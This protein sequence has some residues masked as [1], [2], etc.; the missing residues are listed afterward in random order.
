MA[1]FIVPAGQSSM[2]GGNAAQAGDQEDGYL[3]RVAKYIPAEILAAY[4][5]LL[6]IAPTTHDKAAIRHGILTAALI[7]CFVLTPA[8]FYLRAKPPLPKRLQIVVSTI[9]FPVWSYALGG[10]WVDW[11]WHEPAIASALLI[12][13]TLVA[14]LFEPKPGDP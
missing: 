6:N 10:I 4:V 9:A 12:V 3:D 11:K 8:Y 5:T 13:F 7:A 1:R 2:G 14:G